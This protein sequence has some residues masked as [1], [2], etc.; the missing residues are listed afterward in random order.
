[1]DKSVGIQAADE[2][3]IY[4]VLVLQA[5][6]LRM[7]DVSNL[8]VYTQLNWKQDLEVLLCKV[9]DPLGQTSFKLHPC[10]FVH[11][12]ATMSMSTM[13]CSLPLHN[14]EEQNLHDGY[15]AAQLLVTHGKNGNAM[16]TLCL[17][18]AECAN[19]KVIRMK[20]ATCQRFGW[21][22]N[23]LQRRGDVAKT[24]KVCQFLEG[25]GCHQNGLKKRL[26]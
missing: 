9:I 21:S 18:F 17:Y 26:H 13:G 15:Y 8:L 20:N 11:L 25:A 24:N 1:V 5:I 23:T 14:F 6:F 16:S 10:L 3:G 19:W 7:Q 2:A 22:F 12:A 4:L